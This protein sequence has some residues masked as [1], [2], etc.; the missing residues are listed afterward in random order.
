MSPRNDV[1]IYSPFGFAFYEDRGSKAHRDARGGG[2]A[3]LQASLL[4]NVLAADR[5]HVAHI[6]YPVELLSEHPQLLEV[7]QRPAR[8]PQLSALGVLA[9]VRAVWRSLRD[10]DA[11][12]YLFRT[13]LS[14]GIAAFLVGALFCFVRR[15]KLVLAASNDLDFMFD[16]RD[17]GRLAVALYRLALRTTRRIVVQSAQQLD[18][19]RRVV[20][21]PDHVAMIPSFNEGAEP[22][23]KGAEPDAFLWVGRTIGY[24]LPLRYVE[25]ARS[26][27]EMHFRMVAQTMGDTPK[28][29]SEEL[30]REAAGVP[31]LEHLQK[32]PREQLL[33]LIARAVAVVGTSH[34]EGMPNVFLEAWTR[35][36]PVLSL[37]F[38][39][40]GRID[41][42]GLGVCAE[43]DWER[44]ILG[45]ERLWSDR[46][47]RDE[48]GEH[49]REY[50]AR[51]HSLDAVGKRWSAL[52][53][54]V[55]AEGRV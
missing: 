50:V 13:G 24:K 49:G 45:A 26:L 7:I 39:P 30:A 9:E 19:A 42:E 31:N 32:M 35:G 15:R 22:D 48:L 43:G 37:H 17:R 12:V 28:A 29:L 3:E 4:A 1:A 16:A 14:G 55:L 11:H 20:K 51:V 36:V 40:D 27:P 8:G 21:D 34:H 47:L 2:G 5:L 38:D 18:L 54:E 46:Q 23:A 10:A 25:L 41:S 6:V 53:R 33:E 44:F 52:L